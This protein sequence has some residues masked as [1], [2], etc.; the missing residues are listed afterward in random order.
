MTSILEKKKFTY[1]DYLKT[2][3]DQRCELIEGELNMTPSP[4]PNHQRISRK[5]ALLLE[6]FITTK[7]MGEIFYAPL[8]VYL[9][10]EN[11]FEPDILFISKER[12]HIIGEKNIQGAPELVIEILSENNAYQDL[13]KKKK[14]Y[15]RFG[16]KEY[17]IVD[18]LEKTVEIFTL[19]DKGFQ[20]YRSFPESQTL[21]SPLLAGLSIKLSEVFAF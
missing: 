11:V 7:N 4:I 8:D 19:K 13:V 12:A 1:E 15:A 17:W 20:L 3:D 2:P 6:N 16:V 9:D 10:E 21:E 14:I 18:P 5:I